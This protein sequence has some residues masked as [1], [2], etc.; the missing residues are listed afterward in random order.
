MFIYRSGWERQPTSD[1]DPKY[2]PATRISVIVPARNEAANIEACIRSLL[3]QNYPAALFEIVVVDDHSEDQTAVLA[4][5]MGKQVRVVSMANVSV[6][7]QNSLAYKK[8]A[9]SAG[10][11]RSSGELIITTDADC[12]APSDWLRHIAAS[13]ERT[14]AAMIIGPVNLTNSGRLVEYFQ[15]LDFTTMQGI[16]GAAHRLALGGMANGANLAFSRA[17]FDDVGGYKSPAPQN[18]KAL[19]QGHS[20]PESYR[21]HR[22]HSSSAGLAELPAAANSMGI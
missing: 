21:M 10:I 11:A 13:Y 2:Q 19:S 15:S 12:I 6:A 16:T 7:N 18:A 14:K 1:I 17:A 8:Q 4:A 5:A 20:L 9:L 3:D 22:S